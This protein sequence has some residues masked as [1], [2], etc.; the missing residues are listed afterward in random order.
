[1]AQSSSSS[2][3]GDG[4]KVDE[5]SERSPAQQ[6]E[7]TKGG[8]GEFVKVSRIASIQV[9]N[10][11]MTRDE[12]FYSPKILKK[13]AKSEPDVR[14]PSSRPVIANKP[15][16]VKA[17]QIAKLNENNDNDSDDESV[18]NQRP[19]ILPMDYIDVSPYESN[20]NAELGLQYFDDLKKLLSETTNTSAAAKIFGPTNARCLT[21]AYGKD[22]DG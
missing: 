1:M 21:K 6:P 19:P 7:P 12:V 20:S 9:N 2:G 13:E 17:K 4:S 10:A 15:V 14:V 11:A 8:D 5:P 22:E 3:E 18:I 16:G